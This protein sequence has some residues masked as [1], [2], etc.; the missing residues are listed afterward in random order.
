[1]RLIHEHILYGRV[2]NT[3]QNLPPCPAFLCCKGILEVNGRKYLTH[4][5]WRSTPGMHHSVTLGRFR[6]LHLS[7]MRYESAE[8]C[9]LGMI[10][11]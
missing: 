10:L 7:V 2:Y 1:M 11:N 5:H 8:A 4:A 6:K 3:Q 9:R